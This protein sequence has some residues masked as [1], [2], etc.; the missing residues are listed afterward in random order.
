M[1]EGT[2]TPFDPPLRLYSLYTR[3]LDRAHPH[4]QPFGSAAGLPLPLCVEIGSTAEGTSVDT[5]LDLLSR[6]IEVDVASLLKTV[7]RDLRVLH[8]PQPRPGMEAFDLFV[9]SVIM[10]VQ[11]NDEPS[12]EGTSYPFDARADGISPT[13]HHYHPKSAKHRM[14]MDAWGELDSSTLKGWLANHASKI[15][16]GHRIR[17]LCPPQGD[18]LTCSKSLAG[19]LLWL[20]RDAPP[21]LGVELAPPPV[22]CGDWPLNDI[23]SRFP[24]LVAQELSSFNWPID[25]PGELDRLLA[26]PHGAPRDLAGGEFTAVVREE[27]TRLYACVTLSVDLRRSLVPGVHA[28]LDLRVVLPRH[29]WRR[30][31][32]FP[33][34]THQTLSNTNSRRDK[35]LDGRTFWGIA[36]FVYCY[37]TDC[38]SLLIEQPDTRIPEFYISP[39][40]RLHTSEVGCSDDKTVNLFERNR[41]LIERRQPVGG[42]SHHKRLRDFPDADA[43][44]R[45][46]SSWGR[47]PELVQAVVAASPSTQECTDDD[48]PSILTYDDEI[49]KF[50]VA[51]HLR[52]LPV[53]HDYRNKDA[54]P[55]LR[56]DRAYQGVRG[57]GDGRRVQG[58]IP[59]S[60][61]PENLAPVNT[62]HHGTG[63]ALD[64]TASMALKNPK[65]LV[66]LSALTCSGFGIYL[67]VMQSIPLVYAAL[68]GR[69]I[70]GAELTF[71]HHR[72]AVL[73]VATRMIESMLGTRTCAFLAGE[74]SGGA[75]IVAAPLDYQP[76]SREVANTPLT[77]Q[78]MSAAGWRMAW[79]S[80]TA[81]TGTVIHDAASRAVASCAALCAPTRCLADSMSLGH[82]T[83]TPF[84]IGVYGTQ[85]LRDWASDLMSYPMP[86]EDALKRDWLFTHSLQMHLHA[87]TSPFSEDLEHWADR[88]RPPELSDIPEEMFERLPSFADTRFNSLP[89]SELPKPNLLGP[90]VRMPQQA[91]AP[92]GLCP[93]SAL[94]LLL[95][96]AADKLTHWLHWAL[97]DLTCIRDEGDACSRR[98]PPVMVISQEELHPH[99]R[100]I[101]WD[102]RS[103]P[104]SCGVPLD[105]HADL[106][107]TLNVDFFTRELFDYPN[108]RIVSMIRDG[109]R[110]M[111]DV[112]LQGVFIPHL[113]SLPKGFAS[114][115]KEFKR[116]HAEPL[117]WYGF[118]AN[119]P[120]FPAYY[121]ARGATPRKLEDRWRGTVEGG[122]PRKP[123]WDS[124][125][126]RVLSLNEASRTYHMPQHFLS[127]TR[128]QMIDWL[129][130]RG[131]PAS[132]QQIDELS[133]PQR[134]GTKWERQVMPTLR[135]L[136]RDLVV[137][138]RA[139]H[140]LGEPVYLFGDD[141][142]D[143]FNHVVNAAE[144]LAKHNVIWIADPGDL[145]TPSAVRNNAGEM[146]FIS[147]ERMG[148]GV[149]PNSGIAQE[150][151]EALLHVFRRRVDAVED[152][153]LRSDARPAAQQ[154]L[155]ERSALEARKGGHQRRLYSIHCYCDDSITA[156]VGAERALRLLKEWRRITQESGI[157]MAIP[158]KRSLGTWCLWVGILVF[159][160]LGLVAIPKAKLLR[161]TA[162]LKVAVEDKLEFAIYQSLLGQLEHFRQAICSPRRTMHSLYRPMCRGG[163]ADGL[164]PTDLVTCDDM[165]REQ[166]YRWLARLGGA[167]G[168]PITHTL[169]ERDLSREGTLPLLFI[170]SSD[171]A[172][173]S[174]PPGM[175]GWLH[176]YYWHIALGPE[177]VRYLHITVLEMLA[178][179]FSSLIFR[180]LLHGNVRLT[181]QTDATAAISTL[182]RETER[183]EVLVYAH[184]RVLR[185]QPFRDSLSL[186]D[187]GHL[188][189]DANIASDLVS[190]SKW[191]ELNQ[192]ARQL[193]LRLTQLAL[194]TLVQDVLN[195]VL[196]FAQR[197]GQPLRASRIPREPADPPTPPTTPIPRIRLLTNLENFL[198]GGQSNNE[199]RDAVLHVSIE[200][201]IGVGKTTCMESIRQLF[202]DDPTVVILLEPV[203]DWIE[204]G[205]LGR[206]YSGATSKLEFQLVALA[207]LT[208]PILKAL[209]D[210]RVVMVVSERSPLS[211]LEVFARINLHG[212]DL[213]SYKLAYDAL[214]RAMP[215]GVECF[216]VYLDAPV[217]VVGQR[218]AARAREEELNIPLALHQ[219][220]RE[221]HER[222]YESVTHLKCRIDA[223]ASPERVSGSVCGL[224]RTL[225]P[226]RPAAGE[227]GGTRHLTPVEQAL[228][229]GQSNNENGDAVSTEKALAV[230]IQTLRVAS[231]PMVRA[232]ALNMIAMLHGVEHPKSPSQVAICLIVTI[233][234]HPT[235]VPAN[236]L[237]RG[238]SGASPSGLRSWNRRI[239]GTDVMQASLALLALSDPVGEKRI[240]QIADSGLPLRNQRQRHLTPLEQSLAATQSN[241]ENKDAVRTLASLLAGDAPRAA[242]IR[243]PDTGRPVSPASL[244]KTG[245]SRSHAPS[246]EPPC[247]NSKRMRNIDVHGVKYAAPS[248]KRK[249]RQPTARTR[250]LKDH[251]H[252]RAEEMAPVNAS[253]DQ[254]S[255][256]AEAIQ[257][258]QDLADYGAAYRTLDKDDRAWSFWER[259]C[260]L[261]EW[262]PL[263][264]AEFASRHPDQVIQRL[265][266]FQSWV[267]P[268]L[269]GRGN[270]AGDAKPSTVLNS[271]ALAVHRVLCR[272]H[273]PM[274]RA[275]LLEA[276]NAG[277]KRAYRDEHGT[278]KLMPNK[279]QAM[280]PSM[281]KSIEQLQEGTRLPGRRE[282][283]SPRTR[284]RDKYLLRI[285]RVLWRTGHRIGE[286]CAGGEDTYLTRSCVTLRLRGRPITN[287]T[288]ADWLAMRK[289]DCV[290]LTPCASKCDQS[291]ERWC[292]FPSVLPFDG[293]DE[294][295]AAAIRDI[296]LE[297]PCSDLRRREEAPLF[298][299]ADGMPFTYSVLHRELRLLLAGLFGP[300]IASTLSWHAIRI[301]LACALASANC[302]DAYIQLICRWASPASLN[303][304]RQLGVESNVSWTDRAFAAR[305]DVTRSNNL[306]QLDDDRYAH[307]AA[308][309]V[310]NPAPS[311]PVV[312]ASSAQL[313]GREVRSFDIGG[314]SV[315][316]YTEGDRLCLI[317]RTVVVPNDFW[318]GWSRY[319][320]TD[321]ARTG[322]SR[323]L[324]SSDCVVVG[325]CVR[326]FRHPDGQHS[327]TYLIS[328]DDCA[329]PIKLLALKRLQVRSR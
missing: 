121:N 164:G 245:L 225:K 16:G 44:D 61:R 75:R 91:P 302:P 78:T 113:T 305:F 230:F 259:F 161:A 115:H 233:L 111:A 88:L 246:R 326:N 41:K 301:G 311:A 12:L 255:R 205:L 210:P 65:M 43:R 84:R 179:C 282:A 114:V 314:G 34:C 284:H 180:D 194:P 298:T 130:G 187:L 124:S 112:E 327:P 165:M 239:L 48:S 328:Y 63:H 257:A 242:A 316:A 196:S 299:D 8:S 51:W 216:T 57:K 280:L 189:G 76:H 150:L 272:A 134:R 28:Q 92:D 169:R 99:F 23:Y 322:S 160:T 286:L 264:S 184:H 159:A 188:F 275:K 152:E 220:L 256:L 83:L 170:G 33:P 277:L 116:L 36:F 7:V 294:C 300:N 141:F 279:R 223:T 81:L 119:L 260:E 147:E 86:S 292:P 267:H 146:L 117:G 94:E 110:Y 89:F 163:G 59:A 218:I 123:T 273:I 235:L 249:A 39:T 162:A 241:N 232:H 198:D 178:S 315:Q 2:E 236:A 297:L 98:R 62:L 295:A 73:R 154:W 22:M 142:K 231:S 304:Y 263:I 268:Q 46:R 303:A 133:L 158:E 287:P 96:E 199:N 108:Q 252:M 329:Y 293:T 238:V 32:L 190:R 66:L 3:H 289:G 166:L 11:P 276:T 274:P 143:W 26:L 204:S 71:A 229:R 80:L 237:P 137:L 120:F 15:R 172:T 310:V 105:Y 49:E 58:V 175:G 227:V 140:L 312:S 262:Q 40:Q 128:P 109:V 145:D 313:P 149:H 285:G 45:W 207:T 95:P 35:D 151:A 38:N 269:T 42:K 139:A 281:W 266:L 156:V 37:C 243:P 53:P 174:E 325:E 265:S 129:Q 77:R 192:L 191:A 72:P 185:E 138:R 29:R 60:L 320:D 181:L 261:Y 217:E 253:L 182:V 296:E 107:H 240:R 17:L 215:R 30:V 307:L 14:I 319:D 136:M 102:F 171:A 70:I 176:G 323:T 25:S 206:F 318:G 100:G 132:Q 127:D 234:H 213:D 173:D 278:L 324:L 309:E 50:A 31:Y 20:T 209:H 271:Y 167:G 125:G 291:G 168:A 126:L 148:F 250:A 87:D 118:H 202:H 247:P 153:L 197:R 195:D 214:V 82:P 208:S 244:S 27:N 212:T 1:M 157:I 131:L 55:T 18:L 69:S 24:P 306:P 6:V 251:A 54:Q 67:V 228:A 101:V 193:R 186:T 144:E 203:D 47:F 317:G 21:Q 93:R 248:L 222:L 155:R 200:G 283:W 74:Y 183:S 219:Q 226:A 13:R 177:A 103:S 122:G 290:L 211:N 270:E 5:P 135:M 221:R 224:M 106:R 19:A 90:L 104:S 68:D 288:R 64:S 254:V 321:D 85:P 308:G 97:N 56:E 201:G 9:C 10:Q 4:G 52:G 258:E 79:C